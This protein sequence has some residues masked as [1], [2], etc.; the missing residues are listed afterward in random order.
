MLHKEILLKE[1]ENVS[2]PILAEV[3]DFIRF[4]KA[5]TAQEKFSSALLSE[6]VLAKDWLRQEE[7]DAWADL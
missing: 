2:E 7:D 5:K 3:L 1:L 6:S 4:L